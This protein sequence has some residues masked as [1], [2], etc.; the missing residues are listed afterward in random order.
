MA[1]DDQFTATGPPLTGSGFPRS[2]FSSSAT[3]MVY[4]ANVQGDRAGLYAE[5][6]RTATDRESEVEGVGVAGV[7]DNFGVLGQTIPSDGRPGIAGVFAQ[8]NRGGTGVIGAT[9]RGGTGVVGTSVTS[10]GNPL[11]TFADGHGPADGSGTGV[12]GSSGSGPG[13]HGMSDS[14]NGV[15]A[16]SDTGDA[17]VGRSGSGHGGRFQSGR[18]AD[19]SIV[20]QISLIPQFMDT[21]ELLPATPMA[22]D[23]RIVEVLPAAGTGGDLLV[24]RAADG[25]C[26][27]WFCI[28]DAGPDRRADW[29]QVPLADPPAPAP[30]EFVDWSTT[31]TGHATGF[32]HGAEVDLRGPLGTGSSVD[33]MFRGY[34]SDLFTPRLTASDCIEI[35]GQLGH[36]FVLTFR[37]PV[38]NPVL[39]LASLGSVIQFDPG[40]LTTRLN[41]DADFM[42]SG[43][44]V[45]GGTASADSNGS[46]RLNGV[47]SSISFTAVTIDPNPTIPDGIFLQVG[48]TV[49]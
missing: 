28:R 5:S 11:A 39:L 49:A 1:H 30:V 19:G 14:A 10:L 25:V 6:V 22:Y 23:S 46:V 12:I 42:A 3:G 47:F 45:R 32:L 33:A 18:T 37:S 21:T 40:T 13:V 29:R 7:G 48:G 24:T 4:G 36:S 9:M 26:A 44:T 43:N 38:R 15:L 8:H 17:V 41:G 2:A 27:L 34:D 16:E 35:V 31:A 20:G